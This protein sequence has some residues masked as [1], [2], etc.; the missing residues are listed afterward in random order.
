[1]RKLFAL[2]LLGIFL[3]SLASASLTSVKDIAYVIKDTSKP[4]SAFISAI[5][6]LGY[7]YDLID[8]SKVSSTNFS[9]YE[10]ILIGDENIDNVPLNNFKSVI[11]S[12]RY[13]DGWSS[14]AGS[15]VSSSGMSVI[16]VDYNSIITQGVSSIFQVYTQGTYTDGHGIPLKYLAGTKYNLEKIT[17]TSWDINNYVIATKN[18]PRRV[19]FGI[20]E[21]D[22]WTQD[23]KK[24]FKNSIR[25]VMSGDDDDKDGYFDD[26]DC[27]DKNP[28]IHPNATEIAYDGIDQNCDGFDLIDV[29]KDGFD[30][31]VAGGTDCNDND[32]NTHPG[33]VDLKKNC[34][35]DAPVLRTNIPAISWDED[36]TVQKNLVVY[37]EDPEGDDLIYSIVNVSTDKIHIELD[38]SI[39]KF[40]SD[41]DWFGEGKAVFSASD[42]DKSANSNEVSLKVNSVN[43]APIL[44]FIGDIFV[45][46]GGM[47]KITPSV[48]DVDSSNLIFDFSAP[49]N[50]S[51]EWQTKPGDEGVYTTTVS[52]GDEYGGQDSQ[53]VK[54]TVSDQI[55]PNI[56]LISPLDSALFNNTRDISFAFHVEDNSNELTCRLY[57]NLESNF[58]EII[59]KKVILI[60]S[61]ADTS[62]EVEG[63]NDG[64]YLWNIKCSD[65]TNSVFANANHSFIVSAPDAPEINIINDKII[66]ENQTL[67]INVDATDPD[68]STLIY[69]ARNLPIGAVFENQKFSWTPDFTQTGEYEITFTVEDETQ[70]TDT[71]NVKITVKDVKLPPE[72]NDA[73]KCNA[74]DS[75]IKLD[76][77]K[78]SEGKDFDVGEIIEIKARI[79][80]DFNKDMDF[81]VEAHLYDIS[82]DKSIEDSDDSIDID[83]GESEDV[84]FEIKIPDD[85]EDNDFAVYVYVEDEDG[86][87]CTSEFTEI[88][89]EREDDALKIEEFGAIP[90]NAKRGGTV[91]FKVE[92]QNIGSDEQDVYVVL[93]NTELGLKLESDIFE[94][95]EFGEDD[96]ENFEFEFIV[97]NNAEIGE[98]EITATAFF[99]G[100]SVS[101]ITPLFVSDGVL[102]PGSVKDES[103]VFFKEGFIRDVINLGNGARKLIITE[104]KETEKSQKIYSGKVSLYGEKSSEEP[105]EQVSWRDGIDEPFI[106]KA[107]WVLNA[108][109]LIGSI[110]FVVLL[111]EW[112]AKKR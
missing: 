44:N 25:W 83:K 112:F 9:N 47:V 53:I 46:I 52:V 82:E 36:K 29:D 87:F 77:K 100:D 13:N 38:A 3:F 103:D 40:S 20:T 15:A 21:S 80:N 57:S 45:F 4:Q 39:A 97:P 109:L 27:D 72:F 33:A 67:I 34:V 78:P 24:L 89:I 93:E 5:N 74:K 37:F 17:I 14:R 58:R 95:E 54:I 65:K 64:T 75:R 55:A 8:D 99:S 92:V 59:S 70:L 11:V 111:I 84:E 102:I 18:N 73:P 10:L 106:Q 91:T 71:E 90:S 22:Y 48:T 7:T 23:S 86:E 42:G 108:V 16:N 81:D 63:I 12:A 35:N 68:N 66:F 19:F 26:V 98:Y 62:L 43:D 69:S 104:T 79:D 50:S 28:N 6:E 32:A 31:N 1:M 76:I 2:I 110:I 51:G 94:L 101:E 88:N 107:L 56:T 96:D 85:I 49:L 60:N 41:V 105:E 61:G 30:A